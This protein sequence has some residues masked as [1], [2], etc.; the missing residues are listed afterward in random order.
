VKI[1]ASDA[2]TRLI[3]ERGGTLWVWLD[4]HQWIGQSYVYLMTSTSQLGTTRATRRARSAR[5]PHRFREFPA[6]GFTLLFD[7]GRLDPPEELHLEAKG[8]GRKKRVE[9]YWNGAIFVGEDVPP[10]A[11]DD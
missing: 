6:E 11:P 8:L 7:H 1:V 4:P 10:P 9:A 5:R 3:A 2:V